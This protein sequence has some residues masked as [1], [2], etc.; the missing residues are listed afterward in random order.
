MSVFGWL[1]RAERHGLSKAVVKRIFRK[2][3]EIS[4]DEQCM[5]WE[6]IGEYPLAEQLGPDLTVFAETF[7]KMLGNSWFSR[8]W[9]VQEVV[10]ARK[11]PY[12]ILGSEN[13]TITMLLFLWKALTGAA[14][15]KLEPHIAFNL[16]SEYVIMKLLVLRDKY[17]ESQQLPGAENQDLAEFG[18]RLN[19]VMRET[20]I[21]YKST[22]QHDMIYGVLS[23]AKAP[24]LPPHLAPNYT[25]TF[26]EVCRDYATFIIGTTGDLTILSRFESSFE[27]AIRDGKV[28]T[29]VPDFRQ[30]RGTTKNPPCTGVV[31]FDTTGTIMTV[32]G[33]Q[34]GT[35][36]TVLQPWGSDEAPGLSERLQRIESDILRPSAHRRQILIEDCLAEW[37]LADNSVADLCNGDKETVIALYRH[38]C[39]SQSCLVD[40]TQHPHAKAIPTRDVVQVSTRWDK[41]L[42]GSAIFVA[43][44]GS[45]GEL[46]RSGTRLEMSDVV[47]V[48]KGSWFGSCFRP[49]GASFEFL[50]ACR[51]RGGMK[52]GAFEEEF[53][54]TRETQQFR[55]V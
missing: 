36:L 50:G 9:I 53:F 49:R 31:T 3:V 1:G 38:F 45:V 8:I 12:I 51:F 23:M 39:G 32:D 22:L 10:L 34:L 21:R 26:A 37:L 17:E 54:R 55:I 18:Q 48:L 33:V 4:N 35:C 42:E 44:D 20:S 29:W 5:S 11:P 46:L 24:N 2:A 13:A 15:R 16:I 28:P 40:W 47:C 25:K 27:D 14:S 52:N 19:S 41:N 43:E 30:S 7:V 6:A